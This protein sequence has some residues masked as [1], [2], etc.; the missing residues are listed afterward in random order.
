M[1]A[2]ILLFFIFLSNIAIGQ[3]NEDS[4]K[5]GT[6]HGTITYVGK[7]IETPLFIELID[8]TE[9]VIQTIQSDSTGSFLFKNIPAGKYAVHIQ[10]QEAYPEFLYY[11]VSVK[12]EMT[13]F[14]A[15]DLSSKKDRIDEP[16][17]TV[18]GIRIMIKKRDPLLISI[19]GG[20][21]ITLNKDHLPNF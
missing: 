21:H 18:C 13:N 19:N 14:I 16:R 1:K 9:N 11:N 7:I 3:L 6:L 15:M 5:Y 17:G 2:V 10:R 20:I 4:T 8:S 12:K